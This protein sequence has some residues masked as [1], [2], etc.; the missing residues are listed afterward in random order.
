MNTPKIDKGAIVRT[1]VLLIALINGIMAMF[2]KQLLP[3]SEDDVN[4]A[5]NT[6]YATISAILVI[7]ATVAT[8]WKDNNF[9]KWARDNKKPTKNKKK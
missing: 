7:V 3:V 5:V 1:I 4:N 8:W 6:V 9:T 2:G